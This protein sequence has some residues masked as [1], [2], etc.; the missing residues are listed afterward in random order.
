MDEMDF[1]HSSRESWS[2]LRKLEAAQS[3]WK[4]CKVSLNSIST[5]L[6]KTTNIKPKKSDKMKVKADYKEELNM[7]RKVRKHE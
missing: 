7:C 3:S 4:A 6:H 5:I 2:L 1:T